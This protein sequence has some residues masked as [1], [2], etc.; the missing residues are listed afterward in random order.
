MLV[1]ALILREKYMSLSGQTFPQ[2]T[3]RFLASLDGEE[4]FIALSAGLSK[5][6]SLEGYHQHR[7]RWHGD[8]LALTFAVLRI[9]STFE[10]G[11]GGSV[12]SESALIPA[13]TLLSRVRAPPS[14][15]RP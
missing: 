9:S 4:A 3:T 10:G 1:R 14:A 8:L 7:L 12:V 5:V 13:G 2:V 6:T 11:V 15:P